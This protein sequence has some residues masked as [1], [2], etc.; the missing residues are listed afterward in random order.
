MPKVTLLGLSTLPVV[1]GRLNWRR[2]RSRASV[3]VVFSAHSSFFGFWRLLELLFKNVAYDRHPSPTHVICT[4]CTHPFRNSMGTLVEMYRKYIK[5]I[6]LILGGE[7]WCGYGWMKVD[8]GQI[9][10]QLI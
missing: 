8:L 3:S 5:Q 4:V 10:L 2:G 7:H 6:R 9:W 1:G